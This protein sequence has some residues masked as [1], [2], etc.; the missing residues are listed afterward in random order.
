ML[1]YE[2]D[3][4]HDLFLLNFVSDPGKSVAFLLMLEMT[5]FYIPVKI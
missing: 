5:T 3:W 2:C 1:V 4:K